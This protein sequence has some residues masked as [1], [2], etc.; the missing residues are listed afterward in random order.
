M[1]FAPAGSLIP[2]D[3]TPFTLTPVS[4]GDLI[5]VIILCIGTTTTCTGVSSSNVTWTP[6]AAAFT[7]PVNNFTATAFLGRVTAAGADSATMAFSGATPSLRGAGQEFSSSAGAWTFDAQAGLDNI[8]ATA[9][10]PPVTPAGSGELYQGF[11]FDAG[12]ASA[13]STPGYTFDTDAHGNG[14]CFNPACGSGAQQP[15]WGSAGCLYGLSLMV[16]ETASG[17]GGNPVTLDTGG[18]FNDVASPEGPPL[19]GQYVR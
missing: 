7:G 3:N 10:M 14:L 15:V 8:S 17:P 1:A 18:I 2:A 12:S 6:A 13:G 11:E 5:V 4:A 16:R 19:G 9:A